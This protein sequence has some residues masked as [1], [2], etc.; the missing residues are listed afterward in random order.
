M[1]DIIPSKAANIIFARL[2]GTVSN[3]TDLASAPP[4]RSGAGMMIDCGRLSV[5]TI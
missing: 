3:V 2:W 1:P 4:R 5:Y